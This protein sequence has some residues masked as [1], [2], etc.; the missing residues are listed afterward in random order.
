MISLNKQAGIWSNFPEDVRIHRSASVHEIPK[1]AGSFA[2][3]SVS[4]K[5]VLPESC[6]DL[7]ASGETPLILVVDDDQM[8]C[9]LAQE[10]LQ[11]ADF[12]VAIAADGIQ[13]LELFDHRKPDFV[14]TIKDVL[15]ETNLCADALKL[16]IT[17]S[18]LIDNN[19]HALAT[20]NQLRE[21][22]VGHFIDDFGTGYSSFNYLR[23]FPFDVLIIHRSF[24]S[25]METNSERE[26]IV[27]TIID[28]DH[29]LGMKVVAER[30]E[31][32]SVLTSLKNLP[33]EYAQGYSILEPMCAENVTI[34]IEKR[35]RKS[36]L[37]MNLTPNRNNNLLAQSRV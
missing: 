37:H 3:E 35:D 21:L 7:P 1:I 27:K 12:R 11:A 8:I 22:R 13:A 34:Y 24:I 20:M 26:E 29:N 9:L 23:L 25:N 15:E 32:N 6:D 16:E 30:S 19:Q 10:T 5:G 14:A 28:P 31:T 18:S 4:N 2:C 36:L 17:E 33:C